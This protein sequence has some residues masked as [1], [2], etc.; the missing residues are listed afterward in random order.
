M[1][2]FIKKSYED[3]QIFKILNPVVRTWFK[4][5]F[6]T[7]SDPQ[8]YA[9]IPIHNKQNILVSATTG[10]GKTLTAF[11][12]TLSELITL[13][14]KNKLENKVY[15]VY[16][17]PLKALASDVTVNLITPL[18]EM[19]AQEN[20]NFG[21][22]IGLRT[23]DTSQSERQK[24]LKN[25]P[26]ILI[27]TSESLAI[28][29][30]SPKFSELLKDVQFF[31]MDEL[32]SF[33]ENKR[34]THLSLS[35][36]RLQH[37][38]H[39]LV[40]IGLSACLD[41][42]EYI[43][44]S[45]GKIIKIGAF[46][47][48]LIKKNKKSIYKLV[49]SPVN[50][51]KVL[52]INK[53]GKI[54]SSKVT[55]VWRI[56]APNKIAEVTFQTGKKIRI[57]LN[58]KFLTLEKGNP[59][60]KE[61]S[62]CREGDIIAVPKQITPKN[63]KKVNILQFISKYEEVYTKNPKNL[64]K[65]I[66]DD[67]SKKR[68]I[69]IKQLSK[70]LN[71]PYKKLAKLRSGNLKTISLPSLNKII[72]LS[73]KQNFKINHFCGASGKHHIKIPQFINEDFMRLFGLIAA[74]G[75]VSHGLVE[76]AN[77][78]KELIKEVKEIIQRLFGKAPF[79]IRSSKKKKDNFK[80]I[81]KSVPAS[82]IL[83]ELGLNFGRKTHTMKLHEDL[84][85]LSDKHICALISGFLDG[86]GCVSHSRQ[87]GY[88]RIHSYSRDFIEQIYNCFV[89]L[90]IHPSIISQT[91]ARGVLYYLQITS[92]R[93]R[94]K[95]SKVLKYKGKSQKLKLNIERQKRSD[96]V[97][98]GDIIYEYKNSH[99]LFYKELD[100]LLGVYTHDIV[101][102]RYCSEQLLERIINNPKLDPQLK[103]TLKKIKDFDISFEKIKKIRII[104]SKR[105]Y[106][107]D[108]SV[109]KNHNFIAS[110]IIVHNTAEPI[111][112]LAKFLVGAERE[113]K[114]AKA[115]LSKKLD[116]KVISPV[117][118][119]INV[120]HNQL[121]NRLYSLLDNLIEEHRTT[122]IFTNTRAATERVVHHLKEKF[123]KKY[124]ENIAAHHGSLS[125][126]HRLL[127]EQNLR[128]GKLK[129]VVCSTS[130]ELGIDIGYIDLVVLLG[131]P[132]SVA[133]ASQ[134]IGR[135]GHALH[136]TIKGRFIVLDRDDLV[137]SSVVLKDMVEKKID[138]IHIPENCLDVL[139]QQ[140]F[141]MAIQDIWNV[142]E[143]F[144][145]IKQAYPYRNLTK[146]DFEEVLKYLSGEYAALETRYIYAKIWHD[147]KENKI[148][149]RGK[150]ARV[151]H[152]TNIGT[153][154]EETAVTVK[155]KDSPIGTIDEAFLERLKR[156]DV[157]V[158]GGNTY[159][160][161]FSRGTVAQ[162]VAAPGKNPTVPSWFSEMLPLSFDLASDIQRFRLFMS[163][164]F[165]NKKT[166]EEIIK[167]INEYLYIDENGANAIYE[168]FKEQYLYAEI[169]HER[170]LIIEHYK[171]ETGKKYVIFHSLYGRRV[172]DVLS[173]AIA[174][175]IAKLQ[176][177]DVEIG[178][179]D[180]GFYLA[181]K[182]TMQ[183]Q[184]ALELL[185]PENLE[186]IM[187]KAIEKTEVLK[188]RF[189]HCATRAL[190]ILR[191]YK[192]R[193]K[194][195]G[196]QTVSSM[197][198]LKAVKS[199]SENFSILGEA[200]REVLQDLMDIEN[201][202]KVIKKIKAR[203]IEVKQIHTPLPTPFAFNLVLQGHTDI[204]KMEDKVEFIRRMHQMVLAKIYQK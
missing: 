102:R 22:R 52:S 151:I 119:M 195:V 186:Q 81:L 38:S 98:I 167:F 28:L 128:E 66:T 1:I 64:L 194:K 13:S 49:Y 133:R 80:V 129:V 92:A 34:G 68:R 35:V 171:D 10:S 27:T 204:M 148:G 131:S 61:I 136:D 181:S 198:L 50:N 182:D 99:K 32:H 116:V 19:E 67:V 44:L 84:H 4:N 26:H 180:N 69:N 45:N 201:A 31:I 112:E 178:I 106:V 105:K 203:H 166:K 115:E 79:I 168:Y 170:K 3:E 127:V 165:I 57:T 25:P 135:S 156:G 73:K 157:F 87:G 62:E 95:L 172:N 85:S 16:T 97:P 101:T 190:M 121:H 152:V 138:K 159:Q 93:D 11:A 192:G 189:R 70:Q 126:K 179:N 134:R 162:V 196:R 48:S 160:F 132:K 117:P 96:P 123:P 47:E 193:R 30:S 88:F 51:I 202:A 53:K 125:K 74:D 78:N 108:L 12:T 147:K 163:D 63:S 103:K 33:A 14:E 75:H 100:K 173:R 164:L 20:K 176:K 111:E 185:T 104:K 76:F 37:L 5:K 187:K 150:L 18:K 41:Y 137:E 140:I 199:I 90:G 82:Y 149:K 183:A 107:Y 8:K 72:K 58:D 94:E 42:N 142:D 174:Y 65:K 21:I 77:N 54:V 59:I 113:C 161:L 91:R 118:D 23:G 141:G 188:R 153:I 39:S 17:S 200:R 154:P 46:V 55:R 15:A 144:K 177:R 89:R 146:K 110:N 184:R 143:L 191:T 6:K 86:D 109:N 60:W 139:A 29:L 175:G 145:L 155:I 197:I 120:T 43:T 130:L 56:P 169:P 71:I 158:L 36:E 9:I 7:F 2:E 40:R 83:R 24:M 114:I 124:I 122:L